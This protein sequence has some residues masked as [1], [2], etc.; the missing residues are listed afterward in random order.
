MFRI[1]WCVTM[2]WTAIDAYGPK[3]KSAHVKPVQ[4]L[5]TIFA[6]GK[7]ALH[8]HFIPNSMFCIENILL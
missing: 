2:G 8:G 3:S 1:F 4:K 5:Y 7:R 6:D